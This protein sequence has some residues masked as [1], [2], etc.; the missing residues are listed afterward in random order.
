MTPR[1][2]NKAAY[3]C[4]VVPLELGE[5]LAFGYQFHISSSRE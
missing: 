5:R 1:E 3:A 2:A 4:R